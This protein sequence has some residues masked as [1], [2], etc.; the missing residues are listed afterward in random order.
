MFFKAEVIYYTSR[1]LLL[2]GLPILEKL[3]ICYSVKFSCILENQV[4]IA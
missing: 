1:N 2:L 3:F 4:T